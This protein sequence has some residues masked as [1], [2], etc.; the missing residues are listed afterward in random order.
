M[1]NRGEVKRLAA[2]FRLPARLGARLDIFAHYLGA[3]AG[4]HSGTA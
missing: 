3:A 2:A 1:V 4:Q